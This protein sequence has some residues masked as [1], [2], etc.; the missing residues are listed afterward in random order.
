[1]GHDHDH[2]PAE[3][4]VPVKTWERPQT[5]WQKVRDFL[6]G[7]FFFEYYHELKHE[8]AKYADT[9]NLV[10]YGELLGLP[11]MNSTVGLRL[12]PYMLPELQGFKHRQAEEKEVMEEAPHIH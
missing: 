6:W 5:V 7:L 8:R 2:G 1:M 3:Q 11:L 12:L 4:W 10:L 9:I